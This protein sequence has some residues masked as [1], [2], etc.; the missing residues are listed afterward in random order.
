MLNKFED[1]LGDNM[2]NLDKKFMDKENDLH[3]RLISLGNNIKK[4]N[5]YVKNNNPDGI[6]KE[7]DIINDESLIYCLDIQN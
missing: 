6:K 2:N 7:L 5:N 3:A 4:I 1:E